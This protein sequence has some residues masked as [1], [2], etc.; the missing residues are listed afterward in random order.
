VYI[1]IYILKIKYNVL[2]KKKKST[3]NP[4]ADKPWPT[5]M[6]RRRML[7]VT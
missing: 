4:L 2:I 3:P 1:Y 7:M 6:V 5:T